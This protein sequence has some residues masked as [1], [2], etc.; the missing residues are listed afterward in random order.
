[1]A[2]TAD[3]VIAIAK[4]EVGYLEK[5]SN[6]NLDSK[7]GNAGDKN[8]TKY[9]RDLDAITGYYNGKKNGYEWCTVFVA[10]CFIQAFGAAA[11]K[12]M[13]CQ[14][15]KDNY[16][17]SCT[18]AVK[19]WRNNGRFSTTPK[20]G[21]QIFFGSGVDSCTHTGLVYAVDNNYV[22]TIEG[23]T[24]STSGVVANGGSVQK[25]SYLR[26]YK[27]IVG[28]GE[29]LYD[30]APITTAA[31]A[32]TTI[33]LEVPELKKGKKSST[34]KTVQ[35]ILKCYGYYNSSLDG[36]FGTLTHNAVVKFQKARGL[37]ADGVIGSETWPA[38]FKG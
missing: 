33:K 8:F 11:A 31:P 37:V 21:S 18:Q 35:A 15:E 27:K 2:N 12:K 36:D 6:S 9:A 4:A 10:W 32:T 22:Y 14:P 16:A 29:P 19:Y 13:L 30:A 23:N 26:N 38:L 34:V 28:Y 1:M 3:K 7:T 5:A 20:V 24:S 25:K 17:A